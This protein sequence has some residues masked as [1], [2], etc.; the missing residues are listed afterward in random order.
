MSSKAQEITEDDCCKGIC[1]HGWTGPGDHAH[2]VY[3]ENVHRDGNS[4]MC[5]ACKSVKEKKVN[6]C[7]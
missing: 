5:F 3:V 1:C 4:D 7:Q 6:R 2:S